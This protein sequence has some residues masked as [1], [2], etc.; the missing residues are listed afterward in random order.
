MNFFSQLIYLENLRVPAIM[1]LPQGNK[2][3]LGDDSG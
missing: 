2:A 1:P 3:L